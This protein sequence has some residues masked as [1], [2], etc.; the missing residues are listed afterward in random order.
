[1]PLDVI[2][3]KLFP[4][5]VRENIAKHPAYVGIAS[6]LISYEATYENIMTNILGTVI[7]TRDLKG[8]NELARQLQ[9]RYRLVTLEGDVVNPGGAMTGGTVNKQT[10]SLFS[11]ARELEEVTAHWRDAERK[12][13]ELEQLVQREKEAIAQAEQERTALYTEL[14]ASRMELQ[15]EKAHGWNSIFV[16]NIWTND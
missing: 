12:T 7:V 8:A 13:L 14:E 3:R 2:Q 16:K 1:M 10:N 11:R 4:P 15:E 6:E 5:S 9:Y